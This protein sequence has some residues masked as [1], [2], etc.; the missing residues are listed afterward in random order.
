MLAWMALYGGA[1]DGIYTD[2][3][4]E[5]V[6]QYQLQENI[7]TL[8]DAVSLR[9]YLG[10]KTRKALNASYVEYQLHGQTTSPIETEIHES[11]QEGETT[12]PGSTGENIFSDAFQDALEEIGALS[13]IHIGEIFDP[14]LNIPI[15]SGLEIR[16][17]DCPR[18]DTLCKKRMTE[19]LLK[20][21][22][23]TLGKK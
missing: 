11:L 16:L 15:L 23:Y 10:P 21:K 19:K 2:P 3:V 6:Y 8:Q 14:F 7:L 18:N 22:G 1:F 20:E 12:E 5:S 4:I 13:G 9:G 17:S